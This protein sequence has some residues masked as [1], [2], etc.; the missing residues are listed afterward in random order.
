MV[1]APEAAAIGFGVNG[2]AQLAARTAFHLAH[3]HGDILREGWRNIFD[4]IL[5]FYRAE[6]L[7]TAMVEVEDFVDP[8]GRISLIREKLPMQR[9]VHS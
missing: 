3:R 8:T 5:P 4:I 9:F 7:P 6:L 1:K 2:K